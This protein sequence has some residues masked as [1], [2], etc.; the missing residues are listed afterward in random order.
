MLKL[1][2]QECPRFITLGLGTEVYQAMKRLIATIGLPQIA[3]DERHTPKLYSHFL[4]C[5]LAKH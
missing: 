5:L 1:L 4:E 2:R 3:I